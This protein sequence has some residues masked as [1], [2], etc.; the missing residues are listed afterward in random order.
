MCVCVC[1]SVCLSV[2][3][4]L[5]LYFTAKL[6]LAVKVLTLSGNRYAQYTAL[7]E[8]TVELSRVGSVHWA[9]E[10]CILR[11]VIWNF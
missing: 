8:E 7:K 11:Y 1:L 9:I 4:S 10:S 6:Y 5:V 2:C 3:Y